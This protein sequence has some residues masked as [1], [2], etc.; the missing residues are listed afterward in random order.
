MGALE[1]RGDPRRRLPY[2]RLLFGLLFS[3]LT[4][5]FLLALTRIEHHCCPSLSCERFPS[6]ESYLCKLLLA[7]VP[8][9]TLA[10][11]SQEVLVDSA[12][13]GDVKKHQP[14]LP[15]QQKAPDFGLVNVFCHRPDVGLGQ[16][17][18]LA[19]FCDEAVEAQ[20]RLVGGTEGQHGVGLVLPE[21]PAMFRVA[22]VKEV[23]Q[24][25]RQIGR[26]YPR[27]DG[28]RLSAQPALVADFRLGHE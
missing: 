26:E 23:F 17:L 11:D 24:S 4:L 10:P 25:N 9:V 21:L 13:D 19:N 20:A 27:H 7:P 14:P 18:P 5:L 16:T 15:C 22:Q 1:P 12:V 8:G 6:S 28:L 3:V 2:E